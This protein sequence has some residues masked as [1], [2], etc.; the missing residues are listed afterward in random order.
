M[1]SSRVTLKFILWTVLS[2]FFTILT[3]NKSDGA[4]AT[5][6]WL[7]FL[8]LCIQSYI[9]NEKY[10][11]EHAYLDHVT[12]AYNLNFTANCSCKLNFITRMQKSFTAPCLITKPLDNIFGHTQLY[13]RF[14]S[15][16]QVFLVDRIISVCDYLSNKTKSPIIDIAL[17][18]MLP[19]FTSPTNWTC[20]FQ[21]RLDVAALPLN[22]ALLN[23]MFLPVGN[24]MLNIT[25]FANENEKIWN[26]KFYFLIPE[27]KTIEDDRMG[28]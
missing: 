9:L 5:V 22:G 14:R 26:G 4:K 7:P 25:V 16:Y 12:C 6:I 27:G 3:V 20:P 11:Q 1:V 28:R 21:G 19:Y 23:N 24:Y 8:K 10:L 2:T 15:G 17:P 18:S 13:H